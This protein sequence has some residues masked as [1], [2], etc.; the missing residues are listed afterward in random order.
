MHHGTC[1][2]H[3]PWFMSGSLTRGGGENVPGIPGACATHNFAYLVRGPCTGN[4][5][6]SWSRK[7]QINQRVSQMWAP[8]SVCRE[9]AG[10][11]HRLLIVLY[12]FEHKMQLLI[13]APYTRI[14][15]FWDIV[16]MPQKISYW[17]ICCNT[18]MFCKV[19]IS[20]KYCNA[21]GSWLS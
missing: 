12:V 19:A 1:I 8:L 6:L 3:V 11:Y 13:H 2:T 9:L 5:W 16:I 4:P 17:Q 7:P 15:L 14:V 10:A 21:T 18:P 20:M